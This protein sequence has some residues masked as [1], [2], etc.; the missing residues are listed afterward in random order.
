MAK[1]S[2]E[3]AFEKL[4]LNNIVSFTLTT[5]IS[6]Q[7]VMKKIGFQYEKDIELAGKPHVLYRLSPG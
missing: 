5:N 1:A 4:N 2:C 3:I 7:R 6:S